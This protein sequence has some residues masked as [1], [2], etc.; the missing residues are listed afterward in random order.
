MAGGMEN[1]EGHQ[2]SY[3]IKREDFRKFLQNGEE[4]SQISVLNTF[5]LWGLSTLFAKKCCG[6]S[7]QKGKWL[8]HQ[9]RG[10]G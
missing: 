2:G 6:L 10:G 4:S 5:A 8:H 9:L 3:P 1:G 7:F